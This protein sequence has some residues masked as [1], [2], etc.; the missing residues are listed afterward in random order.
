M[1]ELIKLCYGKVHRQI[2]LAAQLTNRVSWH[3]T[4]KM[5]LGRLDFWYSKGK[6]CHPTPPPP[7]PETPKLKVREVS[8]RGF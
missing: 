1:S 6:I 7:P 2:H 8:Q 3:L 5:T 4:L